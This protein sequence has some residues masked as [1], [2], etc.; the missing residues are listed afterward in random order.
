MTSRL[1]DG[2]LEAVTLTAP[3]NAL[4]ADLYSEDARRRLPSNLD[5]GCRCQAERALLARPAQADA[6]A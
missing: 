2:K 1:H 3:V 5:P 4:W 6:A